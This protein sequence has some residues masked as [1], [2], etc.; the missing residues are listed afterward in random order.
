MSKRRPS[1]LPG[2]QEQAVY[3]SFGLLVT[4]GIGWLIFDQWV[5]VPGDFGS[6][7][8]PAQHWVL[9][10]HGL[11]AY[12]FLIV[13]GALIPVHIRLGWNIARRRNSGLLLIGSLLLLALTA[14]S[15]YYLGG[16]LARHW[17]SIVHW[18]I[19]LAAM[20]VLI[21]H[22]VKGRRG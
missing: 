13:A 22:A 3:W 6:E 5:R 7:H 20:P 9:I 8:H 10:A 2:W 14:L 18:T 4:S 12:A 1:R 17:A 16:E 19:G 21:I 11:A 15:L